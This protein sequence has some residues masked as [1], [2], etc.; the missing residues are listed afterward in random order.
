VIRNAVSSPAVGDWVAD[1]ADVVAG[2]SRRR[3]SSQLTCASGISP[4]GPIH[5]GNLREILVPHFVADE[6]RRRDIDCRHV[7][8]WDDHDRLRKVPAGIPES[9]SDHIG[10]PL[11]S[12]PDPC[13]EHEN[14]AEH[15]KAPLRDALAALGVD[16]IEI[17]QSAKYR[18]GAYNSQI[19]HAMRQRARIFEALDR[20]RT[21]SEDPAGGQTAD[22]YYPFR[23]YC[24]VCARD[25]TT[26]TSFDDDTTRT[27]YTC[28]FGHAG[29]LVLKERCDGKL[30]WKVD[31]PMRWAFEDV[32]FEASGADHSSPGSSFTVGSELVRTVFHGRP[33]VHQPY[34]F[35][36][37]RGQA[38]MSGSMGGAPTPSDALAILEPQL[39]RWLYARRRPNQS[40]TV[41][42]DDEINRL[43]DEWD[44]LV[45][46]IEAGTPQTW[47]RAAYVR[48]TAVADRTLVRTP[49]TLPFRT[50]VSMADIT[51]GDEMQMLRIARDVA[52][53]PIASLDELRPRLDRAREWA[54]AYMSSEARTVVRSEPAAARLRA[55]DADEAE[56]L[57][58][59]LDR[60]DESWSLEGLTALVYAV[61]KIQRGLP[62]DAKPDQELKA[63]QRRFFALLYDLLVGRDTGPRLPT[64]LLSIGAE[65]VRSLL[66]SPG[67]LLDGSQAGTD[68]D[69]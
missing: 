65:R 25:S 16:V 62:L 14:W 33:P 11:T 67:S 24:E 6:L 64:L 68:P 30:V 69:R 49:R 48:S 7:L 15:F 10:R 54:T 59:L 61:T 8:S 41:A 1:L 39:L 58:L 44:A 5:L 51:H 47:E 66:T 63:A 22:S 19:V 31:W 60:L 18:S 53:Q 23:P 35:V 46:R 13:G 42:F 50:L 56:A 21:H 20:Y 12:V 32:S 3:Q 37:L 57:G 28:A 29:E 36:G 17:D 26:I 45:R 55:A 52:V 9:F 27:T 34:S 4:S 38:K 2:E 43:Y 40:I